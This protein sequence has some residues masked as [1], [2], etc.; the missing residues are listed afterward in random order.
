MGQCA[1]E[2]GQKASGAGIYINIWCS[3]AASAY[4]Q[5][6][7]LHWKCIFRFLTRADN[8]IVRA[9]KRMLRYRW[10]AHA[11][12]TALLNWMSNGL[13]SLKWTA[14]IHLNPYKTTNTYSWIKQFFEALFHALRI[15][16]S[17]SECKTILRQSAAVRDLPL[18][19]FGSA[20]HRHLS[21]VAT[22][23]VNLIM[24]E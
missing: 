13:N 4:L 5:K 23:A 2:V 19:F 21:N 3:A 10:C 14:V 12:C 11:R 6:K 1:S 22:A 24:V 9:R 8:F 16:F 17:A 18:I 15:S 7:V 20:L